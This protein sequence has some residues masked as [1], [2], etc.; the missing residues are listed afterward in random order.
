MI[1]LNMSLSN[2]IKRVLSILQKAT[3]QI[4]LDKQPLISSKIARVIEKYHGK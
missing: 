1:V 4:P 3:T 2:N